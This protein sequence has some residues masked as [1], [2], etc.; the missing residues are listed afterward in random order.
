[1]FMTAVNIDPQAPAMPISYPTDYAKELF[2]NIGPYYT[3]GMPYDTWAMNEGKLSEE[4][5][6]EQAYSI[7]DENVAMMRLELGRFDSG[8]MFCYFGITD[9]ISHMYWRY[10]DPQHPKK[11]VSTNPA[12]RNA[13]RDVYKRMDAVIGEAMTKAGPDTAVIVLSDFT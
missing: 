3:Q 1:M 6:L 4:K 2:D 8:L 5:F 7:L 9:L 11:G 13:I 12:V 10:L